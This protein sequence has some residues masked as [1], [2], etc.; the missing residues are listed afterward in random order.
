MCPV[1]SHK[2]KERIEDTKG[3]L[4]RDS[5]SWVLDNWAFHQ[6]HGGKQSRLLWMTG[7]PG[8]GKTMLLCGII[9]ELAHSTRWIT[10]E[11]HSSTLLSFFFCQ[12]T[13]SRINTASAVLGGLA[14]CL[15]AQEPLLIP[16]IRDI[17]KEYGHSSGKLFEGPYAWFALSKIFTKIL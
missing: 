3:G 9:N 1:D 5:Y 8:K 7:D 16:R 2:E 6:W 14:R 4:L 15:A 12:G 10:K 17:M 13:D 11:A